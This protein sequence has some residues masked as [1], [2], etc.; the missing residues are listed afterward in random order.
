MS[1]ISK[2]TANWARTTKC[3]YQLCWQISTESAAKLRIESACKIAYWKCCKL[4]TQSAAKLRTE[5]AT[6]VRIESASQLGFESAANYQRRFYNT[7]HLPRSWCYNGLVAAAPVARVAMI[8]RGTHIGR[9]RAAQA[10]IWKFSNNYKRW[11]F[12]LIGNNNLIS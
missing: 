4:C 9:Y 2:L 12:A 8:R 3:V 7:V 10:G 6:K 11:N 1:S 5:C